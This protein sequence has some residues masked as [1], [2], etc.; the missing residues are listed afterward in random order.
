MNG[1][2]EK[3]ENMGFLAEKEKRRGKVTKK[4]GRVNKNRF[5]LNQNTGRQIIK[6]D[7]L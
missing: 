1:V 7:N 4:D 3:V 6:F 2:G 5:I